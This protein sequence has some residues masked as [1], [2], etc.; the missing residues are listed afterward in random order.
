MAK[1]QFITPDVFAHAPFRLLGRMTWDGRV[2][3]ETIA[4]N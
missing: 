2:L 4:S 3:P 1:C